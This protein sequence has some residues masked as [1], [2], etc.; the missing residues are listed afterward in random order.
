MY[1]RI[2]NLPKLKENIMKLTKTYI[3]AAS[4][5]VT[6]LFALLSG[7]SALADQEQII[8]EQF[9]IDYGVV[10]PCTDDVVVRINGTL[11]V[12][13]RAA[14]DASGGYHIISH[15][16]WQN[17]TGVNEQTGEVYRF[18]AGGNNVSNSTGEL[19]FTSNMVSTGVLVSPGSGVILTAQNVYHVT[20]NAQGELSALFSHFH[21]SCGNQ[22]ELT[23]E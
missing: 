5:F 3:I 15:S 14:P 22:T 6:T 17:V 2:S 21:Y 19:P 16:N 20:M 18:I 13:L 8:N 9:P 1:V 12:T 7:K 4:L 11:H 10:V 23:E